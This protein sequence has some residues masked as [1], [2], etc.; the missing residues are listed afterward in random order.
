MTILDMSMSAAL[1]I[2]AILLLRRAALYRLPKWTFLLLWGVALCRLLIPFSVPARCSVYTGLAELRQA[3]SAAA[4]VWTTPAGLPAE[5]APKENNV[6][7]AAQ[8]EGPQPVQPPVQGGVEREDSGFVPDPLTLVYLTGTA[9]MGGLFALSYLR[10]CR[11]FRQARPADAP[12]L[13]RWRQ[14]HP[15]GRSIRFRQSGQVS[16]PLAYGLLRPVVLFP[17]NTDWEDGEGLGYVLTHEYVHIRRGD[18]W[19]KLLLA[20]AL[21]LHWF[22]P[23]V[24][25]M[26]FYANR[27]LELSCD[28]VVVRA[29][30]VPVK[31]DYALSLL[32]AEERRG[33]GLPLCGYLGGGK[34][35]MKERVT[36]IMKLKKTSAAAAAGALALLLGVTAVFATSAV[37]QGQAPAAPSSS[38]EQT[39]SRPPAVDLPPAAVLPSAPILDAPAEN[40]P[41][42]PEKE[43]PKAV[44]VQEMEADPAP[45]SRYPRNKAGQTYGVWTE[46]EGYADVP[47]LIYYRWDQATEGYLL[48]TELYPYSYPV[49]TEEEKARYYDWYEAVLG[50]FRGRDNLALYSFDTRL[51]DREGKEIRVTIMMNIFDCTLDQEEL[52]RRVEGGQV[53][54]PSFQFHSVPAERIP[55]GRRSNSNLPSDGSADTQLQQLLADQLL[56]GDYPRNR[57]GETYGSGCLSEYTGYDPD[58]IAVVATNGESGYVTFEDWEKGGCCGYPGGVKTADDA[59]KYM[60]WLKTQPTSYFI[61]VYDM[62]HETVVGEF[63][64]GNSAGYD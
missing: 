32:R 24:Y 17:D 33:A 48:R 19:W 53:P 13:E 23:M 51:R 57:K 9:V 3:D 58:L 27:D 45:V 4:E 64:I 44:P 59:G 15:G 18:V 1:M 8:S 22:N 55:A 38:Q 56:D 31:S 34:R 46:A 2:G 21:C 39:K 12:A 36:A 6:P 63:E 62:E 43:L 47:D 40:L 7:S 26:Y 41:E 5:T 54:R 29:F 25:L 11:R 52:A 37:P 50:D 20:A 28:E 10:C 35:A 49:R 30:G 42:D 60:E 61:P 14:S 16:A